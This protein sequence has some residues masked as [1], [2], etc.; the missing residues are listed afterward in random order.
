[1]LYTAFFAARFVKLVL[2][3]QLTSRAIHH[4]WICIV[5]CILIF[6]IGLGWIAAMINE[7][8]LKVSHNYMDYEF[9]QMLRRHGERHFTS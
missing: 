2:V 9:R 7:A 5:I 1:M 8:A 6:G 4:T 3:R